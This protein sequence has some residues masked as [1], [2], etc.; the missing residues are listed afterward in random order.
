MLDLLQD[1]WTFYFTVAAALAMA[2]PCFVW[3]KRKPATGLLCLAVSWQIAIV[4]SVLWIVNY[5][6]VMGNYAWPNEAAATY[7]VLIAAP[8]SLVI[9]LVAIGVTL[10]MLP[11]NEVRG[12]RGFG[13]VVASCCI[14][15]DDLILL[16]LYISQLAMIEA[17]YEH[18]FYREAYSE[19]WKDRSEVQKQAVSTR[20][21]GAS[22]RTLP[23]VLRFLDDV[24]KTKQAATGA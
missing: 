2:A 19:M 13:L 23:I 6:R 3:I 24:S 14:C 17:Q 5:F 12:R 18:D 4:D 10:A 20:N 22:R 7:N 15:L 1:R 11:M 9:P 21:H 8:L 16:V